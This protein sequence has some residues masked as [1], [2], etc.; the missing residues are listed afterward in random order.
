MAI[1]DPLWF[2]TNL[3]IICSSSVKNAIGILIMMTY[4][5]LNKGWSARREKRA[6]VMGGK[7]RGKCSRQRRTAKGTGNAVE[8]GHTWETLSNSAWLEHEVV[9]KRTGKVD[10]SRIKTEA[11]KFQAKEF[12]FH[13]VGHKELLQVTGLENGLE[14]K[15]AAECLWRSLSLS[16][17]RMIQVFVRLLFLGMGR[18]EDIHF[19]CLC[20]DSA[21]IL[22]RDT[23]MN[24]DTD[25]SWFLALW[26]K[27]TKEQL[28][29]NEVKCAG[30]PAEGGCGKQFRGF[31]PRW[32][33]WS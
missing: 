16:Y 19:K 29:C 28:P 3:R 17:W 24:K 22:M 9:E 2:H 15:L 31:S 18:P 8:C 5:F 32:E 14:G 10:W 23:K 13:L 4:T 12:A 33:Q 11:L 27:P 1:C 21:F 30:T 25:P 26:R 6:S 20:D 7:Q